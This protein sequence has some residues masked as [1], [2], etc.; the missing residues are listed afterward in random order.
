M[1]YTR[2]ICVEEDFLRFSNF[3]SSLMLLDH[4]RRSVA[5]GAG[6]EQAKVENTSFLP[7]E[8]RK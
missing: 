2:T 7:F 4:R 5:Y 3:Q 1:K 6:V 8:G